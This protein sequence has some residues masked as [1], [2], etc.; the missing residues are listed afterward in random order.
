[1]SLGELGAFGPSQHPAHGVAAVDVEDHIEVVIR[2]L[3]WAV[4]F[5]YVPAPHGIG[6]RGD[7]LGFLV[8]RVGGLTAAFTDLVVFVQDPVHG[9]HR[10]EIGTLVEQFGVDRCRCLVDELVGFQ[11][12][13]DL[14]ALHRGEGPG[15][16]SG[17]P[18][19]SWRGRAPSMVAIPGG[20]VRPHARQGRRCPHKRGELADG[21]VDHLCSPFSAVLSVAS[22]SN[23]AESFF[24]I[25][26]T[27]LDLSSSLVSRSFSFLSRTISRSRGSAFWR[28]A[29]LAR[30][31]SAPW[32]RWRR[33]VVIKD[34][35]SP[36][37]RSSAPRAERGN[38]SYSARILALYFAENCRRPEERSG[39][40]GSG[41]AVSSIAPAWW[42][43]WSRCLIVVVMGEVLSPPFSSLICQGKPS[44]SRLTQ[45][46]T[47]Y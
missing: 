23:S 11:G 12:C 37:R 18:F 9:G 20:P 22:C 6:F 1:Q 39:T 5:R 16:R 40:P 38:A 13:F 10:S 42:R 29:G 31:A 28:P 19:G 45:R 4:Q 2:P 47:C 43:A 8:R 30:A 32:S 44:H 34:E 24:W 46:G 26:T 17:D 36:S 41:G 15:L 33:Q 35:Y 3:L 7:E 25:S 14:L 27:C 21:L